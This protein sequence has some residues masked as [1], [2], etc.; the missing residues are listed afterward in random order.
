MEEVRD[1]LDA[2]EQLGLTEYEAKCFTALTR[3]PHGTAKEVAQ[4]ADIPRSQVYETMERLARKGLVEIEESEP[5]LFQSVSI[6]TAIRILR[7]QY[8]SY[9]DTVE[10]RLRQIEP[11]YK[12]ASNAVWAI[13]NHEQVTERVLDIISEAEEE[14]VLIVLDED[15]VDEEV[16][17]YLGDAHERGVAI[18]I[19]T[20]S[21]EIRHRFEGSD[22]GA[23][24]FSTDLIEWFAEMSGSPRIG[25]ILLVDRGPS[26]TSAI[27][28]EQLP[29][30]PHETA[31]WSD[32]I[33]H[34]F[35]TFLQRVLT[36]ELE[37]KVAEKKSEDKS[38]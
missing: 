12:E 2:L 22:I 10:E 14:V 28:G 11:R 27:H 18:S 34:G 3:I 21:D 4:V 6:D 36:Y 29:G 15:V 31:A 24:V 32:G 25:R 16:I 37:E 26:L 20:Q 17:D 1:A 13:T 5:R 33:N 9:F 19:G 7:K 8:E 38:S 23:T 30:V 35:A